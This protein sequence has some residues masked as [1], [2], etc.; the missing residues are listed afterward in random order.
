MKGKRAN[1]PPCRPYFQ[2]NP[3]LVIFRSLL[4]CS[5]MYETQ[6]CCN[7]N[8]ANVENR[9]GFPRQKH[10]FN[11]VVG[12]TEKLWCFKIPDFYDR[13]IKVWTRQELVKLVCS[14]DY[15]H[16]A[17]IPCMMELRN[18]KIIAVLVKKHQSKL[19][20]SGQVR[21]YISKIFA[22]L[23]TISCRQAVFVM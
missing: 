17:S 18:D 6:S 23:V 4:T 3:S 13:M 11:A 8:F 22:I 14:H 19:I 1:P 5:R 15:R 12:E 16:R 9:S 2:A 10:L 20:L 21:F 7:A